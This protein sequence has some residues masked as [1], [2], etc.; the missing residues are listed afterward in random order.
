M[1]PRRCIQC[2]GETAIAA[3]DAAAG[4]AKDLTIALKEMPVAACA[5]GHRQFVTPDFPRQLVEHLMDED[6]AKLPAGQ[7]K[8]LLVKHYLCASCGAELAPQPDHRHTFTIDVA[9][10]DL[11]PFRVE[12]TMPV[13]KCSG[14]KTEQLHSLKEIRKH[15]PQA[16]AHAFQA[17]G[18]PPA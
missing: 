16:L 6:E 5:K 8:G 11:G 4:E 7:E 2:R 17:A 9:I 14:C 1:T 13:Y 15:T 18:I 10:A 3:V 12:L